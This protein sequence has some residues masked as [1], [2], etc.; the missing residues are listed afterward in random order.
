ML[1]FKSRLKELVKIGAENVYS[2]KVEAVPEHHP[3]I[4][5]VAIIGLPDK[6]RGEMV[7]AAIVGRGEETPGLDELREFC[8]DKIGGY[9][10]PSR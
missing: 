8:R 10:F 5:D 2:R 9:K 1:Y 7:C 3:G 6:D 4:A